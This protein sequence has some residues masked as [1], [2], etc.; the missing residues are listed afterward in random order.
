MTYFTVCSFSFLRT[1]NTSKFTA[2]ILPLAAEFHRDTNT[3]GYLVSMSVIALGLG[4]I[5]WVTMLRT[6]G[7]RPTF[8]LSLPLLAAMN[9]WSVYAKSFGSLLAATILAAVGSAG[10]EA[11]IS[12]VV[13]DLFLVHQCRTTMMV[14][15]IAL[16]AGFFVGPCINAALAQYVGWRWICGWL[17]IASAVTRV[18]GVFTIYETAYYRRGP[19]TPY[20]YVPKRGFL[21]CW[22]STEAITVS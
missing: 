19:D 4:N 5:L 18:I 22:L 8:L 6:I 9:L 3:T 1:A 11:P 14:F 15:H 16:S 17:A 21:K 2:A 13:A 7:R 10:A 20:S 12:A